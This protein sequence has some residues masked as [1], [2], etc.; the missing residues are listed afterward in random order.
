MHL[1]YKR[2][3]EWSSKVIAAAIEVHRIKGAGLLE[4]IYEK[5]LMR[6]L[7]LRGIPAENQ[8]LVRVEYKGFTFDEPLRLDVYVDRCLIMELKAV[9]VV[10]PIH[11]AKLMSYMKLMDAPIGLIMNFHELI[12]KRG[13]KRMILKGAGPWPSPSC[14]RRCSGSQD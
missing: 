14:T 6:E 9:E 4:S 2:A 3:N 5:C 13:I 11:K 12:L 8:V 10:L 7:E 1:D